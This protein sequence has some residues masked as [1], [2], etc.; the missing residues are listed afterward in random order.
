VHGA[1]R[2]FIA[3]ADIREFPRIVAG[4]LPP[5]NL[6]G[7]LQDIEN[8][9]KPVVMALHGTVLGGGLETAMAG[10]YRV[11]APGTLLGQPEVKL[12]LIPGAGGTQ[13]LPRLCGA[14]KAAELCA[15]GE[16]ISASE[17]LTL[18]I[19]DRIASGDLLADAVEYARSVSQPRRTR[20]LPFEPAD[21]ALYEALQHECDRKRKG[22]TAP[23]KA[24]E[25]I[26]ASL[27]F[28]EGVDLERRLFIECLYGHQA[29]ALIHV[30]FAERAVSK[31]PDVPAALKPPGFSSVSVLG[32]GT[33]GSG[34]AMCFANAG[35]PVLLYDDNETALS[36]GFSRIRRNYENTLR[37][38]RITQAD[39]DARLAL[40]Q[41]V[42]DL[43]ALAGAPLFVEAVFESLELKRRVF[44]DLSAMAAPGAILATNT[45]TLDIDSIAEAVSNPGRVLG[46]HFFSPANVMRLLEIVRGKATAPETLAAALEVARRIGKIGVV[47]GNCFGFLGNRMFYPYRAEAV[48]LV[49]EGAAPREVDAA[50]TEWG[51]AMGPL[52][53]GDLAGLDVGWLIRQEAIRRGFPH[54]SPSSVEDAL[55][56]RGR[57]GQ[58]TGAGWYSYDEQRVASPD[59]EVDTIVAE[60]AQA[61][62]IPRRSFEPREIRER[63][64]FALVNEGAMLLQEG[65]ALRSSDIDVAYVHGYGFPA[66]RGGPMHWASAFGLHKVL[67]RVR[68]FYDTLGPHWKPAPLLEDLARQNKPF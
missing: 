15:L 36:H 59:P 3:G 39:V 1:G 30:F 67:D 11:A 37:K 62:A 64:L 20:D 38:G 54:V 28:D 56:A 40:I 52:A 31:V 49:E 45:S 53:V 10:H 21:P 7:L 4:E 58:K 34:I 16:T 8:T 2:T 27:P 55:Y 42:K 24:M 68:Y 23:L 6:A 18:G 22:Q 29:R 26:A 57:Y 44:S 32:A 5:L 48:R 14:A 65:I 35:I 66:W 17:A 61:Q 43:A 25:A 12:G 47:A 46:L 50:L 51:M 60:Y 13:R 9:P 41:P 19:V 33:M 63:T